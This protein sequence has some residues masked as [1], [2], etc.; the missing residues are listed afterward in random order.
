MD[1]YFYSAILK[2]Y[3]ELCILTASFFESQQDDII[4]AITDVNSDKFGD[5]THLRICECVS[6][7]MYGGKFVTSA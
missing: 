5:Y 1:L 7:F 6:K 2:V 4:L 3:L